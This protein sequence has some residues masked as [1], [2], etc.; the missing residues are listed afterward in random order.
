MRAARSEVRRA[1]ILLPP[2]RRT[3]HRRDVPRRPAPRP[4]TTVDQ[5]GHPGH[6]RALARV[7]GPVPIPTLEVM[8]KRS[9]S[10]GVTVR[11]FNPG[12][13]WTLPEARRLVRA[14]YTV[15]HVE[16]VTGWPLPAIAVQL[17]RA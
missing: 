17:G 6:W 8:P 11:H 15:D 5:W 2:A 7:V 1:P 16:H 14:G 3:G 10:S 4:S 12:T 13:D 9:R